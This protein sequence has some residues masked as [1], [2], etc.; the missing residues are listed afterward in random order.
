[1]VDF[2]YWFKQIIIRKRNDPDRVVDK[3]IHP[4]QSEVA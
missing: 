2:V 4:I 3:K 1:M